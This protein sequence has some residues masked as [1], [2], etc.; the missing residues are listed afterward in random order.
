VKTHYD[1]FPARVLVTPPPPPEVDYT[2]LAVYDKNVIPNSRLVDVVRVVVIDG[3]VMIAADSDR[4]P[5]LIFRERYQPDT[6]SIAK[7]RN[8]GTSRLI[9][10]SGKAVI[11]AKDQH[12]GC[13]SRLRA[14][15]PYKTLGS[16]KDPEQ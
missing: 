13:G 14:W 5:V 2:Q 9:T 10:S 1:I 16:I 15:N 4:G 11:F 6:L 3:M 8:S 7:S 12:C